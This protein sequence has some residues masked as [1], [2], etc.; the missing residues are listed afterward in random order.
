[1]T[2]PIGRHLDGDVVALGFVSGG[3]DIAS[4]GGRTGAD[5][6]RDA[7][8]VASALPETTAP[9]RVLLVFEG[10]RYLFTV[11]LLAV[12]SRGHCA[13][14]PPDNRRSTLSRLKQTCDHVL[15]D[16]RSGLAHR[17]SALLTES[18]GSAS[19]TR[20]AVEAHWQAGTALT[21][22]YGS[23]ARGD[24]R[25]WTLTSDEFRIELEQLQAVLP[26]PE[27]LRVLSRT[28]IGSRYGLVWGILRPLSLRGAFVR[29]MK[30]AVNRAQAQQ[31]DTWISVPAD[32]RES[33]PTAPMPIARV[34]SSGSVLTS[35]VA[36]T[37]KAIFSVDV[38]DVLTVT[39]AGTLAW[40]VFDRSQPRAWRARPGI[41]ITTGEDGRLRWQ[42]PG[43]ASV[44]ATGDIVEDLVSID[45]GASFQ[46]SGRADEWLRPQTGTSCHMAVVEEHV[47]GL[48]GVRD[49][50]AIVAPNTE[51]GR[52]LVCV[53]SAGVERQ[54]VLDRIA[55]RL[56]LRP[57]Q[58]DVVVVSRLNRDGLGRLPVSQ[59]LLL[60]GL[61]ADGVPRSYDLGFGAATVDGDVAEVSIHVPDNYRWFDGHFDQY[62]V[63]PAAVQLHEL[64]LPC[65]ARAAEH[66]GWP[67]GPMLGA[68]RL[69]FTGRIEPGARLTVRLKK[70]APLALHFEISSSGRPCSSGRLRFGEAP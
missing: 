24:P 59:A 45:G 41:T 36:Q 12:W 46:Y 26:W 70:V 9:K 38:T 58:V 21:E 68:A 19:E 53:A 5:L 40:R 66:D 61:G 47:R 13:V 34:I 23:T 11:G 27:A 44:V 1:M 63:M 52:A 67:D 51:P 50:A 30:P 56:D 22:M 10:D 64:V 31:V 6:W 69:K 4:S 48:E 62:P 16:T 65:V 37:A 55:Q 33:L 17:V 7:A 32:L 2:S 54:A 15:H 42:K 3:A 20:A 28:P 35:M 57:P 25:A 8:T 39:G 60:F 14:I 43:D 29:A 49:V 18:S